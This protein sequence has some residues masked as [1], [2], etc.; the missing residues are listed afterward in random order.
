LL[1]ER[2]YV[3]ANPHEAAL[4]TIFAIA[5]I[6]YGRIDY[7]MVDGR[8]Q[9]W[10]INTDPHLIPPDP[11]TPLRQPVCEHSAKLIN[12]ALSELD[13]PADPS[14]RI[15]NPSRQQW[16]RSQQWWFI[17]TSLAMCRL[18]RWEPPIMRT[19]AACNRTIRRRAAGDGQA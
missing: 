14:I 8:P 1:E 11:G 19:L 13:V 15:A 9:V 12:A 17:H 5:K 18:A 3:M 4:R 16:V 6:A 7:G 2:D 10:E